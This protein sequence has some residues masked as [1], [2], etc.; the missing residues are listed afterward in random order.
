MHPLRD[1]RAW[2]YPDDVA[3]DDRDDFE[4]FRQA[5]AR[6]QTRLIALVVIVFTVLWWPLDPLVLARIP[7]AR[8][9]YFIWRGVI[10]GVVATFLAVGPLLRSHRAHTLGFALTGLVGTGFMGWILADVAGPDRPWIHFANTLMFTTVTV[11]LVPAARLALTALIGAACVTMYFAHRP[12]FLSL[13]YG[14][15]LVSFLL[16]NGCLSLLFGHTLFRLKVR[17]WAQARAVERANRFLE[18]RVREK[19]QDLSLLLS[20]VEAARELERTRIAR[21]LHDDL[22][23]ELAAIRYALRLTKRHYERQPSAIERNLDELA[24]LLDRTQTSMRQILQDLRPRVLDDLGP[25][26]AVEWLVTRVGRRIEGAVTFSSSGD[27][28]AL[29]PEMSLCLFRVAQEALNNAV[30][31]AAAANIHVELAIE[32]RTVKLSVRDDGGG[33]DPGAPRRGTGLL[34]MRERAD[35]LHGRLRVKSEPGAGSTVEL[36]LPLRASA[37]P[38]LRLEL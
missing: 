21:D 36:V 17:N 2:L 26:A 25:V 34:G 9:P 4:A 5:D 10:V 30:T 8:G 23:Q 35:A 1:L 14:P 13:A 16:S 37:A 18:K 12:E 7:E 33:F 19:T 28:E 11:P 24:G 38:G 27:A 6:R 29:P 22:G 20:Q 32:P 3:P 15:V 31:H